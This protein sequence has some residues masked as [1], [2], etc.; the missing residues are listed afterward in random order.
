MGVWALA[1]VQT[2]LEIEKEPSE[3]RTIKMGVGNKAQQGGAVGGGAWAVGFMGNIGRRNRVM[4]PFAHFG[5]SKDPKE[6]RSDLRGLLIDRDA[7]FPTEAVVSS[8][9]KKLR[10]GRELVR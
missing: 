5:H 8:G 2:T 7:T 9:E 10:Y 6:E 1:G 4:S 3:W